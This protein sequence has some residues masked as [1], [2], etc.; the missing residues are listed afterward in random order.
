MK[1]HVS[2]SSFNLSLIAL[3]TFLEFLD[4]LKGHIMPFSEVFELYHLSQ[5]HVELRRRIYTHFD[6]RYN[7]NLEPVQRAF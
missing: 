4:G 1:L 6:I 2:V 3:H 7:T 5:A